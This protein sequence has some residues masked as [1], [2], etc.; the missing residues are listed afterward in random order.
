MAELASEAPQNG[1]PAPPYSPRVPATS[2][3]TPPPSSAAPA[4][5]PAPSD[6]SMVSSSGPAPSIPL[7]APLGVPPVG[8]T[9]LQE[10]HAPV[11]GNSLPEGPAP[12]GGPSPASPSPATSGSHAT[13]TGS[14]PGQKQAILACRAPR[15]RSPTVRERFKALT[16]PASSSEEDED[17]DSPRPTPKSGGGWAKIRAAAIEDGDLDLARD[18]GPFAAPVVRERGKRPRWEQVPYA[19][20]KELRKAAK[21]YG[22]ESPFFKNVLDLTFS[23]RTL[24]QHDIKYIA[25]SLLSPTELL[26]WEVQWKKLL[27]PLIIKHNLAATLGT[28]D[29]AMEAIA[30]DGE[31]GQPE[32]QIQLPIPLLDDIREAGRAALLKIPDGRTPSQSFSTILQG[33]DESFI[34]FVDRLREAIEKQIEHPAA[35]E[36]LLRKMAVTNASAETKKILRAL[37]QDPE[38]TITQMVEA[39]VKATSTEVTVAMAVSKGVGEAM[40][41]LNTVRCFGCGQMGHIQANCPHWPPEQFYNPYMPSPRPPP[42][43]SFPPYQPAGNGPRSARRGRVRTTNGPSQRPNLPTIR[44]DQ[45]PRGQFRRI[46][47]APTTDFA[48]SEER[49]T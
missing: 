26:L 6:A 7:T 47:G 41:N 8:G 2:P 18:L 17:R 21:D 38:P 35:R 36:E 4:S 12:G 27:K 32:D 43:N 30:G 1:V 33:P 13:G 16:R 44:E 15:H 23:G 42:R 28:G 40:L 19:E 31:F 46:G 45:W 20:V 49:P 34:K 29:E 14:R 9:G 25:K 39:C 48:S 3:V 11:G 10:G 24:V 37:P 22:R 5:G